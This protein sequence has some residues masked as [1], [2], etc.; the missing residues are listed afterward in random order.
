MG[1]SREVVA[2]A[3]VLSGGGA[4]GAYEA[5]IV[6]ALA[7]AGGVPDGRALTPYGLISG[8]SI[9]ALNAWFVATG[10]YAA[11]ERAWKSLA[12]QNVVRLKSKYYGV[13]R[14]HR[15]IGE[16]LRDA[17]RMA[18]GLAKNETAIAESRPVLDWMSR[19]M[20]LGTP[21]LVP[22]TWAVTNMTTQSAE[23]FYRLPPSF[24]SHANERLLESFR[25]TLG[26]DAVIREATDDIL[27]RALFAS[28]AYPVVFDP[29]ALPTASGVD[30]FY[31][32]GG[33]AS[34]TSVLLAHTIS[35]NVDIVLSV[36]PTRVETYA[37][38]V[39]IVFGAYGTMQRK[40]LEGEM[41]DIYFEALEKRT[42][43][44]AAFV[45]G[46][47]SSSTVRARDVIANAIPAT[48][49]SYIRPTRD[50]PVGLAS[51]DRQGP[52]DEAFGIGI[53]DA[54]RGFVPYVWD[55]FRL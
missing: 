24:P 44:R 15:F 38:A 19:T 4:R 10:Q 49:L 14:P 33:I 8:T 36:P 25:V 31:L 5:G 26:R 32:D 13:S 53:A 47:G 7:R 42:S 55:T 11:L 50:L 30:Q 20:N 12:N 3:L 37:N 6:A 54:E 22:L 16:R 48:K 45:D 29:V 41:R 17:I 9:G 46:P 34:N 21:V 40:I 23:Y 1:A 35:K 43:A 28:A 51:F 18:A 2:R 52:L 27:L 39:D